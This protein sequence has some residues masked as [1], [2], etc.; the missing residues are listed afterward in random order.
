MPKFI[1]KERDLPP[2]GTGV[3]RFRIVTDDRNSFSAWSVIL[4]IP[5]Q[6]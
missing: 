6:E 2:D 4:D 1:I 5:S 3:F